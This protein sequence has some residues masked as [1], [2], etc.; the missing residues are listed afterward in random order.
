MEKRSTRVEDFLKKISFFRKMK[1][2][3]QKI[4]NPETASKQIDAKFLKNLLFYFV[5][6]LHK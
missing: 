2:R 3:F 5:F 6:T 4:Q 1:N